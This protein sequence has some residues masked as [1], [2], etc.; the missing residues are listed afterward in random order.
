MLVRAAALHE[1]DDGSFAEEIALLRHAIATCKAHPGFPLDD[2]G[3]LAAQNNLASSLMASAE[4]STT[5]SSA[6]SLR[7]EAKS[8]YQASLDARPSYIPSALGLASC[9]FDDGHFEESARFYRLCIADL[10]SVRDPLEQHGCHLCLVHSSLGFALLA[11]DRWAEAKEAFLQA[12]QTFKPFPPSLDQASLADAHFGLAQVSLRAS[13]WVE[14]IGHCCK[15][16]QCDPKYALSSF[17][18]CSSILNS[19]CGFEKATQDLNCILK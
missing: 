17:F 12:V 8:L 7:E 1:T 9:L 11:L 13:N 5:F 15:A 2:P 14:T 19:H 10:E 4:A 6:G 3:L 16:L 18:F